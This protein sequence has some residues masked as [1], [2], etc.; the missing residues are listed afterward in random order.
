MNRTNVICIQQ[1]FVLH[2]TLI[3]LNNYLRKF[4]LKFEIQIP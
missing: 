3:G 1:I 4:R 2:N